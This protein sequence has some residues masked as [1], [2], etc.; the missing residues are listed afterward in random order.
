MAQTGET[1]TDDS[2]YLTSSD[3]E[4]PP[5]V[6]ALNISTSPVP[7]RNSATHLSSSTDETPLPVYLYYCSRRQLIDS[8]EN[9]ST[10][11]IK[12]DEYIV[13]RCVIIGLSPHQNEFFSI[14][15]NDHRSQQLP[16]SELLKLLRRRSGLR[17][18]ESLLLSLLSS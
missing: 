4:C 8:L 6:P 17:V 10:D 1:A 16:T 14:Y 18:C 7:N 3:K 5:S 11:N 9:N 15:G 12:P 2:V 13:S